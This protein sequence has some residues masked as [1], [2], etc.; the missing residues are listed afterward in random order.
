MSGDLPR[1]HSARVHRD[2]L[3]VEAGE[4]AL[5][6]GDQLGIEAAL[7]VARNVDLDLAGVR[8]HALA[9]IAV[10]AVAGLLI[11]AEMMIHLGIERPFGQGLLQRIEQS[12]LIERR[13][14]IASG[15]KLIE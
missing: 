10:A 8:H 3:V 15:Q 12:A 14:G 5:V 2:N 7:A 6:L 9:A 13:S 11:A 1:A 4:P